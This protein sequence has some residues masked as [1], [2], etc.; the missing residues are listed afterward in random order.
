MMRIVGLGL[1]LSLS[2]LLV[3]TI[4]AN[5]S[6]PCFFD[7][8]WYEHGTRIGSYICDCGTWRRM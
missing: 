8:R 2:I 7:G 5:A 4:S 6:S 3:N 1:C